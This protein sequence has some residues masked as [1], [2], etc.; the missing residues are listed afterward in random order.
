MIALTLF[1]QS[2]PVSRNEPLA[3]F[4]FSLRLVKSIGKDLG[5]KQ[6]LQMSIEFSEGFS[7]KIGESFFPSAIKYCHGLCTMHCTYSSGTCTVK[8]WESGWQWNK[9]DQI[10]TSCMP[11][12]EQDARTQEPW[13][14]YFTVL[15]RQVVIWIKMEKSS[16]TERYLRVKID[17]TWWWIRNRDHRK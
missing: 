8:Q 4:V 3:V 7:I 6:E 12:E 14:G 16:W 2:V 13:R 9:S 11:C 10:C 17:S 1:S 5:I 15:L